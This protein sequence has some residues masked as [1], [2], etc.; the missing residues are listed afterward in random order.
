[1]AD[2]VPPR[3]DGDERTVLHRLQDVKGL[4]PAELDALP[5]GVIRVDRGG[6]VL[7]YNASEARL[8]DK[9]PGEVVGK[10]FFAEV[11]PCTNVQDFAGR[12]RDGIARGRIHE[13]FPYRFSFERG[14]VHVMVT[15][16]HEQADEDA[17]IFVDA[18]GRE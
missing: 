16:H 2:D 14:P 17:W 6:R 13:T 8:V 11:A 4:S 10:D 1:M 3:L 5:F 7:A 12:F 15:I 18:F 9:S